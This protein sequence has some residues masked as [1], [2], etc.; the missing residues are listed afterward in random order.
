MRIAWDRAWVG[1]T[2]HPLGPGTQDIPTFPHQHPCAYMHTCIHAC[3]WVDGGLCSCAM[4]SPTPCPIHPCLL[5]PFTPPPCVLCGFVSVDP[6]SM[7]CR[8]GLPPTC[9]PIDTVWDHETLSCPPT[10]WMAH[11]PSSCGA[12]RAK[13]TSREK[14]GRWKRSRRCGGR[15]Q[16]DNIGRMGRETNWK[17]TTV[18][19]RCSTGQP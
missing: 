13:R 14:D 12:C 3:V 18:V 10:P 16:A 15:N 2:I 6:P 17:N 4:H 19:Q 8:Y 5:L 9:P 7:W 11:L 1:R